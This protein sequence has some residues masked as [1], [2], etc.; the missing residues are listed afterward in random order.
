[1]AQFKP[2]LFKSQLYNQKLL[3]T[4]HWGFR[5]NSDTLCFHLFNINARET[6]LKRKMKEKSRNHK[7][8]D[9]EKFDNT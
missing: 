1:M 7:D 8:N 5:R 9:W 3:T 4:E 6:F 2:I